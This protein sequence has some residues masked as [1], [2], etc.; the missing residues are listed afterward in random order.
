[1]RITLGS[2]DTL[3]PCAITGARRQ[4]QGATREM[5][6]F[7]LDAGIGLEAAAALFAPENCE[8]I[9]IEDAAGEHIYYG[10][11]IP[12]EIALKS[13]MTAQETAESAAVWED[14]ISVCM[15]QRT[16][17]ENQLASLTET[18]DALVMDSLLA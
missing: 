10:Y 18:V 17:A 15:A 14:K 11:V 4:Y 8:S 7:V 5:M 6:T 9:T 13:V 1:M 12:A 16:Y 2:G 3:E